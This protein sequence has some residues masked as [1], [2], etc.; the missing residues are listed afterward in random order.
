MKGK[1]YEKLARRILAMVFVFSLLQSHMFIL[2]EFAGTAYAAIS[3]IDDN[4]KISSL[5]EEIDDENDLSLDSSNTLSTNE[6]E[7]TE[8]II[9]N[10]TNSNF[11]NDDEVANEISQPD[12]VVI[13]NTITSETT[14][15]D[16]SDVDEVLVEEL[17]SSLKIVDA[18]RSLNGVV[19]RTNI[20]CEMENLKDTVKESGLNLAMPVVEGYTIENVYLEDVSPVDETCNY[21][22]SQ[23]GNDFVINILNDT[24]SEEFKYKYTVV[25]VLNG[26]GEVDELSLDLEVALTYE[27]GDILTKNATLTE[28]I[29]LEEKEANLYS[30]TSQNTSIYKGYLYANAMST[31]S[32]ETK[33]TSLTKMEINSLD[34]IEYVL[35]TEDVDVINVKNKNDSESLLNFTAFTKTSV[36]KEDFDMM[37]GKDGYIEVYSNGT[38]LG[39][40]DKN[41]QV[42]DGMY[43]YEYN[44]NVSQVEFKLNMIENVGCLEILNNKVIRKI[45]TFSRSQIKEFSE[46]EIKSNVKEFAKVSDTFVCLSDEN[47]KVGISLEDTESRMD[48]QM[49][50]NELSTG[51]LNDVTFTVTLRTN[52]EKYELFKNP[53]FQIELPSDVIDVEIENIDLLYKNGLSI[54]SFD[55]TQ[56]EFGKKIIKVRLVGTQIEYTPG[57]LNN[58]TT[59]NLYTKITLDRLTTNKNSKIDFKYSNEVDSKLSYEIDGKESVEIP[60]SFISKIGLLRASSLE[61]TLTDEIVVSYDSEVESLRLED[62]KENQVIKYKGTIV[63]NFSS[64]LT[65]VQIIGK[66]PVVL[67][68]EEE[69]E[70]FTSTFEGNLLTPIVTNGAI[71][72]VFYSEDIDVS[73]TEGNWK[74]DVT[75]FSKIKTFKIVIK[76]AELK[77]GELLEFSCDIKVQDNLENNQ[78]AYCT[79]NVYYD[80]DGQTLFGYCTTK[81]VTDEKEITMEDVPEKDQNQVS[82]LVI[83]SVVT[84][85]QEQL[86]EDDTVFDRQALK[87]TIVVTNTA[88]SAVENIRIKASAENANLYY[89]KKWIEPSYQGGGD[90]EVGEFVEDKN[91]EKLYEEFFIDSLKPGET[92]S[93]EYQVIVKDLKDIQ[94][95]EVF[96]KIEVYA[97]SFETMYVETIKNKIVDGNISV[98]T[99]YGATENPNDSLIYA[100]APLR[101]EVVYTNESEKIIQNAKMRIFI[102]KELELN[103][104]AP[105]EGAQEFEKVI[106]EV[107]EGTIIDII[108]PYMAPGETSYLNLYTVVKNFDTDLLTSQAVIYTVIEYDNNLY[109]SN[110]YIRTIY[111][112]KS[113]VEYTWTADKDTDTTLVDKDV[114][115]YKFSI[116]NVGKIDINE[117]SAEL[118]IDS[119]FKLKSV[120][121]NDGSEIT[122][123]DVNN[124]NKVVLYD[125]PLNVGKNA[126]IE[127][128]FEVDESLL[129]A[130]QSVIETRVD[131]TSSK[132]VGFTT[133]VISFK[134]KN[135]LITVDNIPIDD[136]PSD[137]TS[138]DESDDYIPDSDYPETATKPDNDKDDIEIVYT[139]KVSGKAWIDKNKDGIYSNEEAAMPGVGVSIYGV[140]NNSIDIEHMYGSTKT[141]KFGKY[142]FINLPVGKYIVVFGYDSNMYTVTK[143]QN[144]KAKSNENS[145]AINKDLYETGNNVGITDVLDLENKSLE[146]IDLGL[147]QINDFDM[148]LEKYIVSTTVTNSKGKTK[149]SYGEDDLVKLEINS[150]MF[151]NSVVEIEYKIIVENAGEL[152]GYANR[153]IDYKPDELE[154]DES[155]NRDWK[156]L[157]DGRLVYTGLMEKPLRPGTTH[158]IPLILTMDIEDTNARNVVNNAEILEL[159][160]DRGFQDIDS[161]TGNK[162]EQ[163]DDYGSVALLITVSTGRMINYTLMIIS[164][165]LII[166]VLII[167]RFIFKEKIYK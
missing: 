107:S 167:G 137:G 47:N 88:E 43:V 81:M 36:K 77:Q 120:I 41:T 84:K 4:S 83:G 153:I 165:I 162:L 16:E 139:Y 68:N 78:R 89:M 75:D 82:S 11:E 52:E 166:G 124:Y 25:Y 61:N 136:K 79:Y 15:D 72:E 133:D 134:V 105:I 144:V 62:H 99:E 20:Y 116:K 115:K 37:F 143:Y 141:D 145:D 87:Y 44:Q 123:L 34:N 69:I 6:I 111:Q 97:D 54:D 86:D 131:V 70:D 2:N 12:D 71:A 1:K 138:K 51:T 60:V 40:I 13:E 42:E 64:H 101:F 26:T 93:F 10:E 32:Y 106:N 108:I 147:V 45:T 146:N 55:V 102:S 8:N 22:F 53:E 73:T 91:G 128:E 38:A 110:N 127:Y 28:D 155:K 119:G 19:I 30:V 118:D 148:E 63:N 18:Y 80:F 152:T 92:K 164:I 109:Y 95:P 5:I 121:F 57:L 66:L 151:E 149:Q 104:A 112:S 3:S 56:N 154:F 142:E 58:G 126:Y 122:T 39:R 135:D 94:N 129:E 158:E 114:V 14:G 157:E 117:L 24:A 76:N 160:N 130:N 161:V 132:I 46:I 100:Q 31:A 159:T 33:Y 17:K 140:T 35:V 65:N 150:K 85:W 67:T 96:G 163:E 49:N 29:S 48:L 74:K 103:K 90:Y 98:L 125:F 9:K 156:L 7:Q 21:S 23:E 59:I 50:V 27:E 113:R